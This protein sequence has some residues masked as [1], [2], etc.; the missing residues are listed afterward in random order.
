[1][2]LPRI[3]SLFGSSS[4]AP[5]AIERMLTATSQVRPASE[6]ARIGRQV[7]DAL[8]AIGSEERAQRARDA[9]LPRF[10]ARLGD[11]AHELLAF[12]I[13]DDALRPA[14]GEQA[15]EVWLL[16][17]R[18]ACGAHALSRS[19][20]WTREM[21]VT[22]CR[23]VDPA[24]AFDAI[25]DRFRR[26]P[27]LRAHLGSAQYGMLDII[28]PAVKDVRF[29][30][31]A[32]EYMAREPL[33]MARLLA[34]QGS[35]R[36]IDELCGVLDRAE[37]I[38]EL[39]SVAIEGIEQALSPDAFVEVFARF[40]RSPV[41]NDIAHLRL[42]WRLYKHFDALHTALSGD[43]LALS[44]LRSCGYDPNAVTVLG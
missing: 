21:L 5:M 6:R 22:L 23:S 39:V 9:G 17:D 7:I 24:E 43:E 38:D 10:A 3:S 12:F 2:K 4:S 28:R 25:A 37:K 16:I 35:P 1:M 30:D 32:L 36:A 13:D 11:R 18:H 27:E 8:R 19:E 29:V 14:L 44:R 42:R 34:A 26:D 15:I 31:L 20:E 41:A 40:L 33:V